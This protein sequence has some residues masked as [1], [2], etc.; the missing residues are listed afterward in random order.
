MF[1]EIGVYIAYHLNYPF[2]PKYGVPQKTLTDFTASEF[3]Q[4]KKKL[5]KMKNFASSIH[6]W[7]L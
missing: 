4:P 3:S 7:D 2:Q 5:Y 1:L 6:K